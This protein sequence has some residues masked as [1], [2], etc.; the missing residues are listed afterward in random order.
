[1]VSEHKTDLVGWVSYSLD[2]YSAH[3][4][5]QIFG[6]S[7]WGE[8]IASVYVG[9]VSPKASKE[10]FMLGIIKTSHLPEN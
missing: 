3:G 1:M 5:C 2:I 9:M 4:D 6:H 8:A 10:N 7:Y